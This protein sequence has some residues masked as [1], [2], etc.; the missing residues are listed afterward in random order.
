MGHNSGW[1]SSRKLI[2]CQ[3]RGPGPSPPKPQTSPGKPQGH[4]KFLNFSKNWPNFL[5]GRD[6]LAGWWAGMGKVGALAGSACFH[7]IQ[8][9]IGI[10]GVFWVCAALCVLGFVATCVLIPHANSSG[11]GDRWGMTDGASPL[12]L[13]AEVL[14]LGSS[15]RMLERSDSQRMGGECDSMAGAEALLPSH[16]RNTPARGSSPP[17][18]Q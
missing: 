16:H 2:L 7:P 5:D 1:W 10:D 15:Q 9:A 12:G 14:S 13:P 6:G 4:L 8:K 18:D 11:R 17:E 3:F